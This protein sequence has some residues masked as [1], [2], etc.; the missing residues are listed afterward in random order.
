MNELDVILRKNKLEK[1][2]ILCKHFHLTNN[3]LVSNFKNLMM[4]NIIYIIDSL[5]P[6][7]LKCLSDS[8]YGKK[9][10]KIQFLI[11]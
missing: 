4:K 3:E 5:S 9:I 2:I 7:A 10:Q 8:S 6:L 11:N 1:A